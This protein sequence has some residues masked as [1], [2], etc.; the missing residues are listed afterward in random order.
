MI[1]QDGSRRRSQLPEN[2]SI[3]IRVATGHDAVAIQTIYAPYVVSTAISFE[4]TPPEIDEI[5]DRIEE[6][7]SSYPYLVAT[8][9]GKVIGFCYASQHRSRAAYRWSVDVTAYVDDPSQGRGVGKV[10]YRELLRDLEERGFH[11]AFAGIALPYEKSVAFH[12]AMGF[13]LVGVYREVG[14]KQGSW[15][16]VGW[17]QRRL[18]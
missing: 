3:S 16:D 4:E 1:R 5:K 11:S 14:F 6:I 13:E 8:E 9:N 10:L 17:W 18:S 7:S 12:E 2:S 15:H